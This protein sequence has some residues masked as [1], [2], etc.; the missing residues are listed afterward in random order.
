[1]KYVVFRR[2]VPELHGSNLVFAWPSGGNFPG[3]EVPS[4]VPKACRGL[5]EGASDTDYIKN[6]QI[7]DIKKNDLHSKPRGRH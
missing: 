6:K 5:W 4:L 3:L 2:E 7:S 1:M